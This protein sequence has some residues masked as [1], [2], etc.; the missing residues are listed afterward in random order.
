MQSSVPLEL[1]KFTPCNVSIESMYEETPV[2]EVLGLEAFMKLPLNEYYDI[3]KSKAIVNP[4]GPTPEVKV[5]VSEPYTL[6]DGM[7]SER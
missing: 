4:D 5:K 3:T 1:S 6:R 7:A 2:Q